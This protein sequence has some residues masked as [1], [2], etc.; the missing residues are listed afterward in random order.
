MHSLQTLKENYLLYCRSQKE[1]NAKTLKAYRIDL[2]QFIAFSELPAQD[3]KTQNCQLK[4]FF[5][6]S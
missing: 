2:T 4:G 3:N 6:L 1:L 5:P